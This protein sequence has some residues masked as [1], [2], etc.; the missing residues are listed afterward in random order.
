[1]NGRLRRFG[2]RQGDSILVSE[3]EQFLSGT[4]LDVAFE[5]GGE[6]P[7]WSVWLSAIHPRR[8]GA[9]RVVENWPL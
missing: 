9:A 3:A 5:S 4:L 8:R 2:P 6:V 1:M 7:A